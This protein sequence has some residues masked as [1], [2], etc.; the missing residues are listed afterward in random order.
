MP[1]SAGKTRTGP[2]GREALREPWESGHQ[3]RWVWL[4]ALSRSGCELGNIPFVVMRVFGSVQPMF[5]KFMKMR[6]YT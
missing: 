1:R 2:A 4:W 6:L 3:S 5:S